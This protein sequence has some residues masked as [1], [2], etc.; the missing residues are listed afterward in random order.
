MFLLFIIEFY[1]FYLL[2]IFYLRSYVFCYQC[3]LR[4]VQEHG[5]C[6]ITNYPAK[7]DDLV[8]LYVE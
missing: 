2:I 4:Y 7:E 6:P 1:L 5:K 8:R 3:I